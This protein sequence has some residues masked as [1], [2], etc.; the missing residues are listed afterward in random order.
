ML[1][2]LQ[3]RMDSKPEVPK[4]NRNK[5][6]QI[7]LVKL[8]KAAKKKKM[9]YCAQYLEIITKGPFIYYVST[10]RGGGGVK[11]SQKCDDVIYEWS[12]TK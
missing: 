3:I 11:E 1:N 10:C 9:K 2:K 6:I 8:K 12:L 7:I 5:I 4:K